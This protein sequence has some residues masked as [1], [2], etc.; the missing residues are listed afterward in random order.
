M[1]FRNERQFWERLLTAASPGWSISV[2]GKEEGQAP[3][4]DQRV[5]VYVLDSSNLWLRCGASSAL[6]MEKGARVLQQDKSLAD[7]AI[8]AAGSCT[9]D[10]SDAGTSSEEQVSEVVMLSLLA[11]TRTATFEVVKSKFGNVEGHWLY[12]VYRL[13]DGSFLSR[14]GFL[15]PHSSDGN[16]FLPVDVVL[17]AAKQMVALDRGNVDGVV[18]GK[19]EACGGAKIDSALT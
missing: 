15:R 16:G 4:C 6:S 10:R 18:R 2:N 5:R 17:A 9:V 13:N 12:M 11:L 8:A 3:L 14:P 7:I 19:M 1:R